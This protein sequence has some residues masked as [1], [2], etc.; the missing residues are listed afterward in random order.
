MTTTPLKIA[1]TPGEPAGIGPDLTIALAHQTWPAQIVV[2]ADKNM[3]LARA[4]ALGKSLTLTDYT[5][6]EN[7]VQEPGELF[8]QHIPVSGDV[9]PGELNTENGHYVVET[10]RQAAEENI[11]GNFDAVVTGAGT[12]RCYQSRRCII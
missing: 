11:A 9:V 2:F 7:R 4:N 6:G 10:L 5:P 8:I 3:L 12:Q 1:I